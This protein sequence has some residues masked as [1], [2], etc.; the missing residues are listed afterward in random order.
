MASPIETNITNLQGILDAVNNLP[1]A[2]AVE[3]GG[4]ADGLTFAS[5][6]SGIVPDIQK[7][8]APALLTLPIFASVLGTEG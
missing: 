3:S 1:E 5:T 2:S 8:T 4:G 6:A 7:A